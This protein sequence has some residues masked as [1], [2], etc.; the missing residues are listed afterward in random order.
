M[1]REKP[2]HQRR[3]SKAKNI[4]KYN[5]SKQEEILKDQLKSEIRESQSSWWDSFSWAQQVS[6]WGPLFCVISALGPVRA[7]ENPRLWKVGDA[8]GAQIPFLKAPWLQAC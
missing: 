3:L 4:H 7:A 8:C 1:T 6:K 2:A 5:Y